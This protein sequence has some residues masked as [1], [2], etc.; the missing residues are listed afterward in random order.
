MTFQ[1]LLVILLLFATINIPVVEAQSLFLLDFEEI[2]DTSM[3]TTSVPEFTDG[4]FDYFLRT[5]GTD[6]NASVFYT[7]QQGAFFFGAQDLNGEGGPGST[8][9]EIDS[10]DISSSPGGFQFSI[11]VAED[12]ST[13]G[14]QDWDAG[15]ALIVQ[16]SIDG[17][18]F[19]DLFAVEAV[20]G[21]NT[22]P[23]VDTDFDGI[24]DGTLIT[25]DFTQFTVQSTAAGAYL[26][27]RILFN[28]L[29]D[30]DE[31]IA[32]D[33][34]EI[35]ANSC[36]LAN[37][38]LVSATCTSSA[39]GPSNDFYDLE[40]SY[41]GTST[42]A[43]ATT[44]SGTIT[45]GGIAGELDGSNITITGISEDDDWSVSVS[46]DDCALSIMGSAP[47]CDPLP[48]IRI[49][50]VDCDNVGV[51]A[52][53][54]IELK[55]DANLLMDDL[56]LVLYNGSSNA[57]Y[58]SIDL[59]GETIPTDSFYV[60][61]FQN[62]DSAYCDIL[63][64]SAS[65]QNGQD[66]IGL[67]FGKSAT[68]FPN[69]TPV[70]DDGLIDGLVYDTDD[71]DDPELL[72]I[73]DTEGL[74]QINENENGQKDK[75]SIQRGSWF[76]APPTPGAAN[77]MV[78]LPVK[79]INF[80]VV[81]SDGKHLLSWKTEQEI[82]HHYF[83]VQHSRDGHDFNSLARV[84]KPDS[85]GN[86]NE[87]RY[88]F[89]NQ[90]AG[91]HYY[92]LKQVDMDGQFQFSPVRALDNI[93][94]E[95]TL[96]IYP[97][98]TNDRLFITGLDPTIGA[99]VEVISVTGQVLHIENLFPSFSFQEIEMSDYSPGAFIIRISQGSTITNFRVFVH[100]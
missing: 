10:I 15:S 4:D 72:A 19:T 93:Q 64:S 12:G 30:G 59:D 23:A 54:F 43:I 85:R 26:S 39:T 35:S 48:N 73:L 42:T 96:R 94:S 45:N 44:T 69:G 99:K 82:N 68:D 2:T 97:T 21:T 16:Y 9:M 50:E 60:I 25:D 6:I 28:E 66:G 57:S 90:L 74:G 14:N 47:S 83:A 37:L 61:C 86:T 33:H 81:K 51:D 34:I 58:F 89:E 55:G 67:Y 49:N 29:N 40:I 5:D 20:G 36:P 53:E 24:G 71:A 92:R 18:P 77:T 1:K 27:L 91:I 84:Y 98:V 75:E 7:N 32:I 22:Q 65:L 38:E 8:S 76:V 13:D 11:F 95:Q 3:Y 100:N 80:D 79:L 52:M 17:G 31:D 41:T 46:G 78:I 87:Y 88:T 63:I 70:T 56:V 62:H